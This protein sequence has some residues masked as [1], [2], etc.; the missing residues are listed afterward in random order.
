MKR[1]FNTI[2]DF[3]KKLL[4]KGTE[5]LQEAAADTR[6]QIEKE[7]AEISAAI[8]TATEEELDR[9]HARAMLLRS[10]LLD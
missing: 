5:E 4:H 3:F 1:L 2:K 10:K 7:L 8:E 6:E 9:L